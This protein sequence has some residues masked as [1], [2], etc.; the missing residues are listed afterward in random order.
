LVRRC[1]GRLAGRFWPAGCDGLVVRI[2]MLSRLAGATPWPHVPAW[3]LA[4]G[5]YQGILRSAGVIFALP[6]TAGAGH[7][8]QPTRPPFPGF[9]AASAAEPIVIT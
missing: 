1:D 9:P 7:A 6:G 8:S 3:L 2:V 5:I 4:D